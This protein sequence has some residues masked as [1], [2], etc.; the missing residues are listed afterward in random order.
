MDVSCLADDGPT[1]TRPAGTLVNYRPAPHIVGAHA[2]TE[3][4]E[5]G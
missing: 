3:S 1:Q 2:G 5:K 4:R